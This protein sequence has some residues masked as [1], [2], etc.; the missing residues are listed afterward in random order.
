MEKV[1]AYTERVTSDGEWRGGNPVAG[2]RATP[3]KAAYFNMVQRELVHIVEAAGLD[4]DGENDAQL[5]EAI[6]LMIAATVSAISF[7]DASVEGATRN[8]FGEFGTISTA[9]YTANEI[10]LKDGGSAFI[11]KNVNFTVSTDSV[12]I[13]GLDEGGVLPNTHYYVFAISNGETTKGLISTS[14]TDPVLPEGYFY[15]ALIGSLRTNGSSELVRF[16][17]RGNRISIA[18]TEAFSG[19]AGTTSYLP[20]DISAIVPVICKQ[21]SGYIGHAS[22]GGAFNISVASNT[23]N[24]GAQVLTGTQSSTVIDSYAARFSFNDVLCK[25]QT[26]Y[27]YSNAVGASSH[28]LRIVGYSI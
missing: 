28:S 9:I 4:L 3:M 2:E 1:G 17:Q 11:S 18:P 10:A 16:L 27:W 25:N 26:I 20:V 21:V 7:P 14:P 23:Q 8:L 5:T 19:Q 6:N 24:V 22:T 15:K 13:D 12:G